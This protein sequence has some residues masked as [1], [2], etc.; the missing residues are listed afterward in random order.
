MLCLQLLVLALFILTCSPNMSF[1]DRFISDNS[2]SMEKYELEA[3]SHS[4]LYEKIF[5]YKVW[6]FVCSYLFVIFDLHSSINFRDDINSENESPEPLL[7]VTL[8]GPKW[9]HWILLVWFPTT[10]VTNYTRDCILH[11][12]RDIVFSSSKI[13]IFAYPSCI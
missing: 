13:A 9:Y 7:G 8:E 5:T 3:L 12:F 1:L 10:V 2:R 6:V 4:H 11:C